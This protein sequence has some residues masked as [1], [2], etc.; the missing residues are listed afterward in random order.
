MSNIFDKIFFEILSNKKCPWGHG[1]RGILFLYSKVS[2]LNLP[3]QVNIQQ[4]FRQVNINFSPFYIDTFN[5]F[6]I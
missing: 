4:S 5:Y 2:L 1:H 3:F 6:N